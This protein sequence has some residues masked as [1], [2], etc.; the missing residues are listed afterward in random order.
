MNLPAKENTGAAPSGWKG[1]CHGLLAWLMDNGANSSLGQALPRAFPLFLLLFGVGMILI[2]LIGDQGLIAFYR[3]RS[4]ASALREEVKSLQRRE[5]G[6][7]REIEALRDDPGYIEHLARRDLG[8]I[9]PGEI[10]VQLP[11][12]EPTP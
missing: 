8:L 11:R 3:L 4:E 5:V 6:L 2:S 7:I 12:Q 9:K 1:R 10:V